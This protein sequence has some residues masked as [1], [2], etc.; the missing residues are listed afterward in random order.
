MT[1]GYRC[2]TANL[3]TSTADVAYGE[4]NGHVTEDVTCPRKVNAMRPI[5]LGPNIS[6]TA[7]DAIQQ[8]VTTLSLKTN[9]HAL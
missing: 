2:R 1:S 7:G 6:K 4:S 8:Q 3:S 5:R 9:D